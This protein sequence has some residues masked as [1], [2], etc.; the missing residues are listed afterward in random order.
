MEIFKTKHKKTK[1]E[2]EETE[3]LFDR[4]L[5]KLI[6]AIHNK[7]FDKI[8]QTIENDEL[9]KFVMHVLHRKSIK[10]VILSKEQKNQSNFTKSQLKN[11]KEVI[12]YLKTKEPKF[13]V[14]L[15][16]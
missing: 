4:N 15:F 5:L 16:N 8:H 11:I 9:P 3:E 2:Y 6:N 10:N 7:N 12:N 14:L 1:K 13:R